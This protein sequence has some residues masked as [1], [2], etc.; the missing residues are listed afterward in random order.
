VLDYDRYRGAIV[1]QTDAF[2][3][4]LAGR[5]TTTPVP[6]CPGWTVGQLARHV[7]YGHR[8][9]TEAVRGR[10]KPRTDRAMRELSQY[11]D[12]DPGELAHWLR[13]GARELDAALGEAG[14]N[15]QV[16]TPVPGGRRTPEF[17]AR[18]FA[19]E[20]LVH[21]V[22]A[23][24]ALGE[25]IVLA[26]DLAADAAD[27]WFALVE[28][29]WPRYLA[30]EHRAL[31]GPDRTLHFHATDEHAEWVVDLT[32]ETFVWRHAHEKCA[33]AVR[34]PLQELLLLLYRRRPVEEAEVEVLGDA[35]L[36]VAWLE[37]SAFG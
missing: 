20:T 36:L 33:V 17:F 24:L 10:G 29:T 35:G 18:R 4:L 22:D 8:W 32:G 16:W 2:A 14:P 9:A 26:P 34:G 12:E 31:H 5:D 1:E 15:V 11:V 25:R 13:E 27:E 21:R 30:E 37:V 6:S 28:S 23:V 19:H 3:D 7:G